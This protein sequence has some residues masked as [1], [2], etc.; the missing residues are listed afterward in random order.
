[1]K[2]NPK[3]H[4][5]R[6]IRL[7]GYNYSQAG[8]YFVTICCQNRKCLFGEIV[9][10]EMICNNVGVMV[11]EEWYKSENIRDEIIMHEFVIMPNHLHGIV[12]EVKNLSFVSFL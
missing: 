1:M 8:L 5:R 10:G 3:I 2:Y 11:R 7:R 12:E 4:H 9:N 6:S